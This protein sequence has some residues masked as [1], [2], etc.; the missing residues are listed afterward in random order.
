M[1]TV[2][3][4]YQY[5]ITLKV[6]LVKFP[7][8]GVSHTSHDKFYCNKEHLVIFKCQHTYIHYYISPI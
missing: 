7:I 2:N 5:L 4:C 1:T 3:K 6:E 8:T